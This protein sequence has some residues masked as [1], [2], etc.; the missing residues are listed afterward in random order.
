M[1]EKRTANDCYCDIRDDDV[2]YQHDKIVSL[3]R[4]EYIDIDTNK[5]I[6]RLGY[7]GLVAMQMIRPWILYS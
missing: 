2:M 7:I 4:Y 1:S 5:L 6:C 3:F